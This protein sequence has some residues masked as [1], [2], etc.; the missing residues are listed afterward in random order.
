L[1]ALR[2]DT[3][4]LIKHQHH[5]DRTELFDLVGDPYEMKHGRG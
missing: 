3:A 2:T 5:D 4:K 1:F